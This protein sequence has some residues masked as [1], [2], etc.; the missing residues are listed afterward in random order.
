MQELNEYS[1]Q[2][3]VPE[4]LA[5]AIRRQAE[6]SALSV[7]SFVR[8]ILKKHCQPDEATLELPE[9]LAAMLAEA[10]EKYTEEE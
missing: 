10:R 9:N 7:S 8:T 4:S 6:E 5:T 3:L 1:I 2:V